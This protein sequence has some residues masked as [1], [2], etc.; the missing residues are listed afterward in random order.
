MAKIF[1]AL[2]NRSKKLPIFIKINREGEINDESEIL[3]FFYSYLFLHGF[4]EVIE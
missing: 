3:R 2:L 1:S 4:R